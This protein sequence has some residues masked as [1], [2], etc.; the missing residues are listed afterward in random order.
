LNSS[1]FKQSDNLGDSWTYNAAGYMTQAIS[2][3]AGSTTTYAYNGLNQ[4]ITQTAV[5]GS[6]TNTYTYTYAAN[7]IGTAG[8]YWSTG[9]SSGALFSTD[10]EVQSGVTTT[11]SATYTVDSQNR[12]S[13]S[14]ITSTAAGSSP[15]ITTYIYY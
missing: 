10:T 15:V 3:S 9:K 8:S 12:L 14:T 2:A 5:Y 6:H 4:L 11:L 13:Q 7:A 1:G